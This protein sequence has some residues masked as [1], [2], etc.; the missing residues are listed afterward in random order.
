M[1][2]LQLI[3]ACLSFSI[4]IYALD[5]TTPP[6]SFSS[7][8]TL[9]TK[10]SS[11]DIDP[12][13]FTVRDTEADGLLNLIGKLKSE[14]YH[15][16]TKKEACSTYFIIHGFNSNGMSKWILEMKDELFKRHAI[17][18]LLNV[19][20]VN[21]NAGKFSIFSN[22]LKVYKEVVEKNI[23][24]NVN[25]MNRWVKVL[26]DEQYLQKNSTTAFMHC[27]G[28][29]LGAHTCGLFA[30]QL[31][32]STDLKPRRITGLDP[33]GPIFKDRDNTGRLSRDDALFVDVI[34]TSHLSL[35]DY[36][37]S[38]C[39]IHSDQYFG[40][41]EAI[42][43]V[44][45][46]PNGGFDQ[47]CLTGP[48]CSHGLSHS[49]FTASINDCVFQSFKCDS[50]NDFDENR[51]TRKEN[52]MGLHAHF[53]DKNYG[54]EIVSTIISQPGYYLETPNKKPYCSSAT[55]TT[56]KPSKPGTNMPC[57]I[58][59]K[60]ELKY[61]IH[62]GDRAK[63]NECAKITNKQCSNNNG[64]YCCKNRLDEN[65]ESH[66]NSLYDL[67]FQNDLAI[68]IDT[69]NS[70]KETNR[71]LNKTI[72]FVSSLIRETTISIDATRLSLVVYSASSVRTLATFNDEHTQ[73]SLIT[74]LNSIEL[75]KQIETSKGIA[76]LELA[77]DECQRLFSVE[78]GM[79]DHSLGV[80]KQMLIINDQAL[81]ESSL[82]IER[83]KQISQRGIILV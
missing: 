19:F 21:W 50:Y 37:D 77:L 59:K 55:A 61:C 5:I 71:Q 70:L 43:H 2:L 41:Y 58:D 15:C 22:F 4:N 64:Y 57:V 25:I 60:P 6:N 81:N 78:K 82:V 42:G 76:P 63:N 54:P 36:S 68:V 39:T 40:I 14:K 27:I 38:L 16:W 72:R 1:V 73:T 51:C 13:E 45:F 17:S 66:K 26:L 69:T 23:P 62:S 67:N 30:K 65:A 8:L 9:Y 53:N 75:D 48:L 46:Y 35:C 28:H 7:S 83:L 10:K 29:S 33:A 18:G 80:P 3:I 20:T 56:I 74:L 11:L 79:R 31:Y 52:V 24:Y 44:N 49:Y 34:H 47:R 12:E 32:K